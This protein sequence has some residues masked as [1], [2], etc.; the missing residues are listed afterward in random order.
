MT[1][2]ELIEKMVDM[3]MEYE[4]ETQ[5]Q[6]LFQVLD[7]IEESQRILEDIVWSEYAFGV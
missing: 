4:F 2:Q 5:Q 1:R 3:L 6:I 7:E